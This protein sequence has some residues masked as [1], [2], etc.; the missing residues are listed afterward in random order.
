M[1][2]ISGPY[3]NFYREDSLAQQSLTGYEAF[4]LGLRRSGVQVVTGPV[5]TV[6]AEGL[7]EQL[8]MGL[9]GASVEWS[10]N[11]PAA[12]QMAAAAAWAGQRAFNLM[13]V[14]GVH[15]AA[16]ALCA[17]ADAGSRGG[18]IVALIGGARP[19]SGPAEQDW[20][21]LAR[22][23]QAPVLEPS[24]VAAVYTLLHAG[25]DLSERCSTP[26]YLRLPDSIGGMTADVDLEALTIA[27]GRTSD[28]ENDFIRAGQ[29]RLGDVLDPRRA[30][31]ARLAEA[32]GLIHALGLNTLYLAPREAPGPIAGRA[33]RVEELVPEQTQ[34]VGWTPPPVTEGWWSQFQDALRLAQEAVSSLRPAPQSWP[35]PV[36]D[37][38]Q[39]AQ[40]LLH[41]AHELPVR[42]AQELLI[43]AQ[44]ALSRIGQMVPASQPA[45]RHAQDA[46]RQV[47]EVLPGAAKQSRQPVQVR[48]VEAPAELRHP[49]RRSGFGIIAAGVMAG[50]LDEGL[51]QIAAQGIPHWP[52]FG[53]QSVS[54]LRLPGLYPLPRVEIQAL[55]R[56][57]NT[58]LILEES[59]P[60]IEKDLY[61]EAF[62]AEFEGTIIG[63]LNGAFGRS[64]A[65]GIT[66]VL[67][68][69]AAAL[70]VP[71]PD[72]APPGAPPARQPATVYPD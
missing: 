69:L 30:S 7:V 51:A 58:L 24:S 28:P 18:L 70:E 62:Q 68:G 56:H 13:P 4:G 64:Y 66:H 3:V 17:I 57:C 29:S 59:E 19:G 6:P 46:L 5:G 53:P 42:Q 22:L 1:L 11:E 34:A 43:Q 61:V 33:N 10:L 44:D 31:R 72:P 47:Q 52:A 36:Q 67:R 14:A 39:Q 35:G 41:Q 32:E 54:I 63:K 49:L 38:W 23:S 9:P 20:C 60:Y 2:C 27:P 37:A 26:V 48:I 8:V 55:M 65:G 16:A 40:D 25:F 71:V 15:A 45:M 50:Y 21:G 12:L